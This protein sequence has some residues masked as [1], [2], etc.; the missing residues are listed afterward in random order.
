MHLP[1]VNAPHAH[2]DV[3]D[4]HGIVVYEYCITMSVRRQSERERRPV[5]SL[6]YRLVCRNLLPEGFNCAAGMGWDGVVQGKKTL[7]RSPWPV[8]P[9][10]HRHARRAANCRLG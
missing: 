10:D 7:R 8:H 5:P 4:G 9:I 2:A 6:Q 1:A 3:R